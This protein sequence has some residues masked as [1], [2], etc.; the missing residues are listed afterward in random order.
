[1]CAAARFTFAGAV[2]FT[3]T[4]SMK[5]PQ[6]A[7]VLTFLLFACGL[8]ASALSGAVPGERPFHQPIT[9]DA[10]DFTPRPQVWEEPRRLGLPSAEQLHTV[11]IRDRVFQIKRVSPRAKL[12]RA[13]RDAV[14]NT[15]GGLAVHE[16]PEEA[17]FFLGSGGGGRFSSER[18]II[19]NCTFIID[20]EEGDFESWD[21]RRSAVYVEGY[22][23]VIVRNS[24]FISKATP[25]D[26]MRKVIASVTAYD[27]L[28]VEVEDSYFEG[29]TIGWRGHLNIFCCGPTSIRNVEVNG[30]DRAAGGIWVATGVGEGKIGWVHQDAPEKMI[31]PPGPLLIENTWVRDQKGNENS[32]G[33]YIQ[34]VQP[35]LIRNT[36]VE[37]WGPD[38]SLIDVGFR[39]TAG[40]THGGRPLANHGGLGLIEHS[41]FA[42]GYIKDSVGI[43]GGLVFRYNLLRD[44]AWFFPYVFDGGSWFVVSNEFRDH[45]GVIVSGRNNQLSGWTPREGM[46]I[47]GSQ[48][49]LFNN[50]VRG[51]PGVAPRALFVAGAAPGPLKDVIRSDFNAYAFDT[52]P[53]VW[54]LEPGD[55]ERYATLEDWRAA[56]GNDRHSIL[57]PDANVTAFASVPPETLTLPGGIPMRFGPFRAGLTGPVGVQHAATR[58]RA[59]RAS[60]AV[61]AEYARKYFD[62]EVET[63]KLS[64]DT[65]L[66]TER[67]TWASGGAYLAGPVP[68][69]STVELLADF[70]SAERFLVST[71]TPGSRRSGRFQFLVNGQP[72]GEPFTL[73]RRRTISHGVASF[74]AGPQRFAYRSLGPGPEGGFEL[75][76]DTLNFRAA[77]PHEREQARQARVRAEREAARARQAELDARKIRFPVNELRLASPAPGTYSAAEVR[78]TAYRVFVPRSS[79]ARLAWRMPAPPAPGR[80]AVFAVFFQQQ[81]RAQVQLLVDGTPAGQGPVRVS[82]NTRLGEVDLPA[83]EHVLAL[84]FSGF[85][86]GAKLRLQR[87]ELLP[88]D[89]QPA[90]DDDASSS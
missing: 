30:L 8:A 83:G 72:L 16:N 33:I 86:P 7:P 60:A 22:K 32:D 70:P 88:L 64:G 12:D 53:A 35:Y 40:K 34:S 50:L 19:E 69:G 4:R 42:K 41:E 3:R 67:R 17:L 73:E 56:T 68:A 13:T 65:P 54:G 2:G 46:F 80:F 57:A 77:A 90:P 44:G 39:D 18:L 76:V 24:V 71:V 23:E 75:I 79:P 78:D 38:D 10:P 84:E 47:N 27:C 31:Y 36:K 25:F 52:P 89:Q 21:P 81:D 20:F 85:N 5:L 43:G 63:M 29:R 28:R 11:E 51:R 26:P 1:M 55:R 49:V 59:A 48:M 62:L 82:A 15:P 66:R 14:A 45:T 87:I 74:Q 61:A 6:P 37:N 58:E 9:L